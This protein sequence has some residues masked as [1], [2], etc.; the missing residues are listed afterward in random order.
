MLCLIANGASGAIGI[1]V[2]IIDTF[3]LQA[4]MTI[5]L[6]PEL[7]NIIPSFLTMG[8]LAL[9]LK[10]WQPKKYFLTKWERV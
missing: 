8:V 2:G 9:F 5:F 6:G 1:P 3:G 10:K 7:T 4:I